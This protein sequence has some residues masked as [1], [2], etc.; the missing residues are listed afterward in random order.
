[1]DEFVR[2]KRSFRKL[3][4]S[5]FLVILMFTL[6]I[7]FHSCN[8]QKPPPKMYTESELNQQ[9]TNLANELA[10]QYFER[11]MALSDSL[12]NLHLIDIEVLNREKIALRATSSKLNKEIKELKK[13]FDNSN[14]LEDCIA[15][16]QAQ[17]QRIS[18]YEDELTNLEKEAQHWCEL[19]E[20][21][22]SQLLEAKAYI[23][24]SDSTNGQL[25]KNIS[26]LQK[27]VQK[28]VDDNLIQQKE[29]DKLK[30][31]NRRTPIIT[32]ILGFIGGA[33]T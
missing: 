7:N 15:L 4:Y 16:S 14:S 10:K 3:A 32:A 5:S 17:T 29:I 27:Q 13:K 25:N 6:G 24:N 22:E 26:N 33:L 11:S 31:K 1:M 2:T 8:N 30:K 28:L 23:V 21:T 12:K 19:Y 18:K 20:T 9:K